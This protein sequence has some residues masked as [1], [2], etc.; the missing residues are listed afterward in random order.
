MLL[1]SSLNL[2][3]KH[4]KFLNRQ[5]GGLNQSINKPNFG[6]KLSPA[7]AE[8]QAK[9]LSK[10]F[11]VKLFSVEFRHVNDSWG[12]L[13]NVL[14]REEKPKALFESKKRFSYSKFTK[15][16]GEAFPKLETELKTLQSFNKEEQLGEFT[17]HAY[18]YC[19]KSYN[20]Y[21]LDITPVK[22]EF[23]FIRYSNAITDLQS[24]NT[25]TT[26]KRPSPNKIQK[27]FSNLSQTIKENLYYITLRINPE[28]EESKLFSS[29][30]NFL[31]KK[32]QNKTKVRLSI[33]PGLEEN[34]LQF[35]WEDVPSG[36]KKILSKNFRE[37]GGKININYEGQNFI[38]T[39]ICE[40]NQRNI[41]SILIEKIY[42]GSE[43]F[44]NRPPEEKVI[45]FT[46][47][48]LFDEYCRKSRG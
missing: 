28:F 29:V 20:G 37:K 17:S 14:V 42:T 7:E 2:N 38:V 8:E 19:L 39:K 24:G 34:S 1:V 35:S 18:E 11:G 48:D 21:L 23:G 40:P 30:K 27:A 10:F 6:M 25:F 31:E 4:N 32:K 15:K 41:K 45:H 46:D 9:L 26:D 12:G 13:N 36:M 16:R 44:I 22:D 47:R 33:S 5:T 43:S 3:S